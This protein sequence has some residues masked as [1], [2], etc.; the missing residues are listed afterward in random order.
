MKVKGGAIPKS[1]LKYNSVDQ[2]LN[3]FGPKKKNRY[4]K[5]EARVITKLNRDYQGHKGYWEPGNTLI[6]KMGNKFK[7]TK[8]VSTRTEKDLS[9]LYTLKDNTGVEK[10]MTG[11]EMKKIFDCRV[12]R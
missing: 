7:I 9:E 4:K 1:W 3:F 10:T 12:Q 8:I 2:L 5:G 11:D 6:D